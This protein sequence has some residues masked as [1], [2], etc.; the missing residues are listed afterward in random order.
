MAELTKEKLAERFLKAD[1]NS[2]ATIDDAV[3]KRYEKL[4]VD[5]YSTRQLQTSELVWMGVQ[6]FAR[7]L[8]LGLDNYA[9]L[10]YTKVL[11]I[12]LQYILIIG[13]LIGF[14]DT[15]N[16]PLMGILFDRTRTR[17][18]KARPYILFTP[19]PYFI[20][21]AVLYCGALFFGNTTTNDPKKIIFLF[22]TLFMQETF[23]TIF[24]IPTDNYPTL[25][26]ACPADRISVSLVQSYAKQY[27]G[28]LIAVLYLP[29]MTLNNYGIT[30]IS[31]PILFAV[32]GIVTSVLGTLGTMGVAVKC[33]ERVILQAKPA[34]L[35][36]T[37]FYVL[38][39]KYAMRLI[40]ANFAVSWWSNGG[41]SWDVIT[42][43]EI[44]GGALHMAPMYGFWHLCNLLSI[45][46][47][48]PFKEHF[49]SYR[50]LCLTLRAWD[51][52]LDIIWVV[53]G[54]LTMPLKKWWVSGLVFT[55]CYGLNGLNNAP[56]TAFEQEI[57]RE[58][59]DYTEYMTGE[60]PDGTM[61][62]LTNYTTRLTTPLKTLMAMWVIKWSGYDTTLPST[63]WAQNSVDVYRKVFAL[64]AAGGSLVPTIINAIPLFFYDLDGQ[65]KIDMYKALNER[66]SLMA[67]ENA[68]RLSED[69]T[70]LISELQQETAAPDEK[71]S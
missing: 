67:K 57:G 58:I 25:Q 15:L 38:K 55:F 3:L 33:P 11:K 41:Y 49:K 60:R 19:L 4:A 16:D 31:E 28:D 61:Y 1:E 40:A 13:M 47:I 18:G 39:N 8:K 20:S 7:S 64:Y 27:G 68:G 26:S 35:T 5:V 53:A 29:L 32:L 54:W 56:A 22:I 12:D 21:T 2:A 14:Y 65:K 46:L 24:T 23:S 71:Q 30:N 50:N 6:R 63:Y 10:Y 36:K 52:V 9:N 45:K 17:W 59:M 62:L 48:K 44:F 66:R 51:Y 42:Q 37:M 69:M 43:L 34:P 70:A